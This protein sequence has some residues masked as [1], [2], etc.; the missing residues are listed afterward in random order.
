[1]KKVFAL[2]MVVCTIL[3]SGMA[4][5]EET[6]LSGMDEF[7]SRMTS[8]GETE[9]DLSAMTEEELWE[10][11]ANARMEL[12]KYNPAIAEG[13][14]FY[15]DENIRITVNGAPYI[16]Y[17]SL[18]FDII[19]ENFTD[20]N[21][22]ASIDNCKINGWDSYGATVSV[23]ANGKSKT[24]M[25]FYNVVESAELSDV[26]ELQDISGIVSYFDEDTY[27]TIYESETQ[28]WMFG[29]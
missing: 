26:S 24:T 16:E 23:S 12:G 22:I 28:N 29:E 4:I 19:I 9:T 6:D 1:M 10:L 27:E 8:T 13:D 7:I 17:E 3:M 11:I 2:L 15:E 21:I 20:M 18:T 14:V 25:D 5:A